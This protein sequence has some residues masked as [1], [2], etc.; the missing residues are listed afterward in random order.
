MDQAKALG[1]N[2]SQIAEAALSDEVKRSL[3]DRWLKENAEAIKE[4]NERVDS[5]GMYIEDLRRF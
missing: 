4:Y 5:R 3:E 1:L 2:V